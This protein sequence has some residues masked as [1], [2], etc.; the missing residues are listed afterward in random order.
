MNIPA[1]ILRSV[2]ASWRHRWIGLGAAWVVCVLGWIAV[3][4]LPNQYQATAKLYAEADAILGQALR[5]IAVDGATQQQVDLLTRTLLAR[6]TLERVISRTD[7]DMRVDSERAREMLLESLAREIRIMAQG[8]SLFQITYTDHDP[9]V[10][11]AVVRTLL[12]IFMERAASNDR[13]QMENA[14][15]FVNQQIDTYETQLREAERRRAEFRARYLDLLPSDARGGISRL[16]ASR[17][18]L[19]ELRGELADAELR[20]EVLKRQ[21][22]ELPANVATGG[23]NPRLAAAE[24]ELR[25]LRLRYTDQHPA[26]IAQRNIVAALRGSGE[27]GSRQ[28]PAA[29][30]R[31]D[32]LQARLVDTE[33]AIASLE[34]QVRSEAEEVERLETL[35]RS[36]PHLQ[37]EFDNLDRDYGVLRRQYEEL[38]A[39]RESLQLAGA[40]RAGADQVRI[41]VVEPPTVPTV[42]RGPNRLLFASVVLVA[43]LGA[44]GALAVLLGMLDR[45]FYTLRDLREIGLPVLGA[46][47]EVNPPARTAGAMAFA[48][49]ALML[50]GAF[51]GVV[52]AGPELVARGSVL[53]ARLFA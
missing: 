21:L 29:S 5:G 40:A 11:Q 42:P 1:P 43:G 39:R 41:E 49:G 25:E 3:Y 20:R 38:L 18:R 33:L 14:R 53:V 27:G 16:E 31:R 45:G 22:D 2:K 52:L 48:A 44:G 50:V 12:D 28:V 17:A 19:A 46:I 10:A 47:A 51:A 7:L 37:A 24:Q 30:T 26:V 4:S 34:R 35:A 15:S 8:R 32:T 6:P 36:A 13:Q 23:G 9:R